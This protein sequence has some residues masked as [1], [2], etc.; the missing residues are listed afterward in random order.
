MTLCKVETDVSELKLLTR[1]T[2]LQTK[3]IYDMLQAI[4]SF[5]PQYIADRQHKH[6]PTTFQTAT[7][8][9]IGIPRE[10]CITMEV[11]LLLNSSSW[12]YTGVI[13]MV[14]D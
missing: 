8:H 12:I 13:Y 1:K 10:C 11:S 5:I 2:E 14:T 4:C 3:A 6:Q 7:G 9:Y